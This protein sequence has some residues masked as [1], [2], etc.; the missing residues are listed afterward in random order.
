MPAAAVESK[1]HT[2]LE[3]GVHASDQAVVTSKGPKAGVANPWAGGLAVQG[4]CAN[5]VA[6]HIL[7]AAVHMVAAHSQA[8]E[9]GASRA[10]QVEAS[11]HAHALSMPVAVL[12]VVDRRGDLAV[13]LPRWPQA[14]RP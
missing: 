7:A 5:Q 10:V 1:A 13:A 14:H 6:A 9:V 2:E 4:V 11:C 12:P 3:E 8:N